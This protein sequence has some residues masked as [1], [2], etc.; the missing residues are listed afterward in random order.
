MELH[1]QRLIIREF[2]QSDYEAVREYENNPE[3]HRYEKEVI[4]LEAETRAFIDEALT[5]SQE[6]PR[7]HYRLAI[8]LPAD[9]IV[10]GRIS[11][12]LNFSEIREWEIGWTLHFDYWGNGYASEAAKTMLAFAFEELH[13]HRVVA[14]CNAMNSRSEGV[15]KKIG[16]QQDGRLR[17]TRWWNGGWMDEFVYAI[18]DKDWNAKS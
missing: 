3:I 5:W 17:E 11:L 9:D 14:F 4:P 12:T 2:R 16:M 18:L 7:T 1:S 10:R 13:A 8:T 6:N 15:M